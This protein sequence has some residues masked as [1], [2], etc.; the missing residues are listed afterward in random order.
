[1]ESKAA[2][3]NALSPMKTWLAQE[4]HT[5]EGSTWGKPL[6]LCEPQ[7]PTGMFPGDLMGCKV[8]SF[9]DQIKQ[10]FIFQNQRLKKAVT[11]VP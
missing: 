5:R 8:Q 9:N 2:R 11:P 6:V 10:V 3:E 4:G 7:M 1:M